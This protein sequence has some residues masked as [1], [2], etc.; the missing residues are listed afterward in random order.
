MSE[1]MLSGLAC[2]PAIRNR[3]GIKTAASNQLVES[4]YSQV[5]WQ[6]FTERIPVS[7]SRRDHKT[8]NLP[9]NESLNLRPLHVGVASGT[10]NDDNIPVRARRLLNSSDYIDNEGIRQVG[11]DHPDRRRFAA[12]EAASQLIRSITEPNHH[13][14]NSGDFLFTYVLVFVQ[15]TGCRLKRNMSL[16]SNVD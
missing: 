8:V 12:F 11:D 6:Y 5:G 1:H 3:D 14:L 2:T 7:F 13:C 9:S 15:Y 10:G 4:H 16:A